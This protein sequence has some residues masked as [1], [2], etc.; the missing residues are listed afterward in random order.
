[1][2]N[3][4]ASPHH[5]VTYMSAAI[6][7]MFCYSVSVFAKNNCDASASLINPSLINPLLHAQSGI[8]GTGSPLTESG[9]GGTGVSKG[10]IGGTGAPLA[11]SGIG[12]TGVQEGGIGGSGHVADDGGIGGTG[13]IG[14]ITGFA[15]VCI[16]GIE[17]HYNSDTPVS[18]D[19]RSSTARDLA[20]GQIAAV[21]ALVT[22]HE[23]V[24]KNITVMHA[25]IGPISNFNS[26]TGE[27]R[28]LDQAVHIG[29]SADLSHVSNLKT[30]DW[31][32]V[33]GHRLSDGAI[34]ASRI[35]TTPP[36]AQAKINGHVTQIDEQSFVVNGTRVQHDEKLLPA[37]ISKGV[38]IQV[39][40]QWDGAHLKAQDIQIEPMLRSIGNVEHLVIEGYIHALGGKELNVG[41]RIVTIDSDTQLTEV[42][43]NDLQLNQRVLINGRLGA[44]QRINSERIEIRNLPSVQ[45][46]DRN[47][48]FFNDNSDK[49]RRNNSDNG[50]ESATRSDKNNPERSGHGDSG[51]S[52]G[53]L[54]KELDHSPGKS[55]SSD[56]DLRGEE[57]GKGDNKRLDH[58]NSSGRDHV[59]KSSDIRNQST[60]DHKIDKPDK[61]ENPRESD[62]DSRDRPDG[63]KD[64]VR[65]TDVQ[66]RARDHE[67]HEKHL[68]IDRHERPNEF[69]SSAQDRIGDH[70]ESIRDIDIPDRTRD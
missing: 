4:L 51:S 14:V 64:N 63:Y 58:S 7:L 20:A 3:L 44:D 67:R 53:N 12:G 28:V 5:Y 55:Q 32:Q 23:L 17:V 31:V 9:V 25:A 13:I 56:R 43:Q 47:D 50:S 10:G 16:S 65:D 39:K 15:S 68:I 52:Q 41:N 61:P 29:K 66:D 18:V 24:A 2:K 40:G 22:G 35:E 26:E 49:D 45:I 36:Q 34:V 62:S 48:R 54:R 27:M 33:S 6:A 1:M 59:E 60:S 30:G 19:G 46:Q 57:R 11:D 38:E 37:G 21:R 70:R 69:D 8:G 42:T